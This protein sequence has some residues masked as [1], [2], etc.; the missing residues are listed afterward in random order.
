[1]NW[2]SFLTR[3]AHAAIGAANATP[4]ST[5]AGSASTTQADRAAPNAHIT[6]RKTA[7]FSAMRMIMN[8]RCPR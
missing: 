7:S 8:S 3:T 4:V 6:T 1:M 5:A 2:L